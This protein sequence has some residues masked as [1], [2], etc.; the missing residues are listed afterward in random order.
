MNALAR[1]QEWVWLIRHQP[2]TVRLMTGAAGLLAVGGLFAAPAGADST[3]DNFIDA[4]NHA[5]VNFG[6][7]GNAMAVGQSIC[8]MLVKPGGSV[9]AA[10]ANVAHKGLSPQMAK[11]FTV[12]AIQTYCPQEIASL[13]HGNLS[14]PPGGATPRNPGVPAIPGT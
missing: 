12:I 1:A 7:P 5:G 11:A 6:E 2:L 14:S 9:A 4:L 8:P 13:S 10:V 3:D